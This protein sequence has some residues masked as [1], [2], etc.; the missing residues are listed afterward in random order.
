VDL[1]SRGCKLVDKRQNEV[2]WLYVAMCENFKKGWG[3]GGARSEETAP[4]HISLQQHLL[5]EARSVGEA[6]SSE[7]FG[8]RRQKLEVNW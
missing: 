8:E 6:S 5:T 1:A 2:Y 3:H 4:P 7:A